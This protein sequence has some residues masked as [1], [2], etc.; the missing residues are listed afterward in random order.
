MRSA[1]F[2]LFPSEDIHPEPRARAL[3]GSDGDRGPQQARFWLAAVDCGNCSAAVTRKPRTDRSS[4]SR[5]FPGPIENT[6][7]GSR[8]AAAVQFPQPA[9]PHESPQQANTGLAGDPDQGSAP[10]LRDGVSLFWPFVTR[11]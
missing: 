5:F 4:R 9:P 3:R 11:L 6:A 10:E 8:D 2:Q 7:L 1:H